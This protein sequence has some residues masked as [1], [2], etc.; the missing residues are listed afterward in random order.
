MSN[1][2][3][4]RH[5]KTCLNCRHVVDKKFC[6]N[7]GQKNEDTRKTFHH[8]FIHFFEDLTHYEGAF[9]KTIRNLLFKPAALTTEYLSGKRL[10]YLAP[11]RL[12]LFISF[13]TFLTLSLLPT[14]NSEMIQVKEKAEI[15]QEKKKP[16]KSKDTLS[17]FAKKIV[18]LEK[19][20]ILTKKEADTLV[21]Y[22][23]KSEK[24]S[25]GS[26]HLGSVN[27]E[28]IAQLD[29]IQ[30]GTDKSKKL[31]PVSYWFTKKMIG[32]LKKYEVDELSTK[33]KSALFKNIPKVLFIYMPIFGFILW[34]FH[35]KKQWYYFD[36][37]IFT[38]HYFS[39]LLLI[40]LIYNIVDALIT[41]IFGN[42]SISEI[43]SLT[44]LL[45]SII[46][47]YRAHK[48]FYL[49][50]K[51]KSFVKGSIIFVINFIL[52]LT[53]LVIFVIFTFINL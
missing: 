29:S 3:Q 47:F 33:F 41:K 20:G 16:T 10:S 43:L 14:E 39:F 42:N 50:S 52:S 11:I 1:H 32:V 7:C 49:E 25:D 48:R 17:S 37:G 30:N 44:T 15:A 51:I 31:G 12:Y 35:D 24:D 46:Y 34:L 21:N 28:S 26:L 4:I 9:W 8:L 36:H 6:S 27:Y 23:I 22:T 40:T 5:D 18:A 45:W 38:L 19:Q 2:E 53:I 13:I